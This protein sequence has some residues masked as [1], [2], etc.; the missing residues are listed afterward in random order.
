MIEIRNSISDTTLEG[1][2]EVRSH[3]NDLKLGA[4]NHWINVSPDHFCS[5]LNRIKIT[6]D[7]S[8]LMAE[9]TYTRKIVIYSNT[10]QESSNL[11]VSVQTAPLPIES[12]EIPPYGE[13]SKL[14]ILSSIAGTIIF[15]ISY[16]IIS[17]IVAFHT[18][19]SPEHPSPLV[20]I[21]TGAIAGPL[22]WLMSG[23]LLGMMTIAFIF[24]F[25]HFI[26][27]SG[28]FAFSE[29]TAQF[30]QPMVGLCLY[31][32]FGSSM[33][34]GATF[35]IFVFYQSHS[36]YSYIEDRINKYRLILINYKMSHAKINMIIFSTCLLGI[37]IAIRFFTI[38]PVEVMNIF[39]FFAL[40]S[41]IFILIATLSPI[42]YRRIAISKYRA[43]EDNLIQ[44]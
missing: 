32:L 1:E 40:A 24:K 22:C 16:P 20:L 28:S 30:H 18:F 23:L 43:S 39:V 36:I 2:L 10:L 19:A 21:I 15:W 26:F 14:C 25:L 5:N 7:T 44:P 42:L 41:F 38:A 6:I 9:K 35:W 11:T 37:G 31:L 27:S 12:I 29:V 3:S 34:W 4:N 8:N 33:T 13:L 17:C